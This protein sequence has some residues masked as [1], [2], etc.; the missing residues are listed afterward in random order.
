WDMGNL[1]V[2]DQVIGDARYRGVDDGYEQLF[3]SWFDHWL[4]GDDNG[5]IHM[6]KVQLYIPGRGWVSGEEWPLKQTRYV[7][8]F[9]GHGALSGQLTPRSTRGEASYT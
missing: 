7:S 1:K 9:L 6:P 5:V 3:L 4:K 8:F 2:G